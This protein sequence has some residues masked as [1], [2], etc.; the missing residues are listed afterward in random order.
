[1]SEYR[2]RALKT[3]AIEKPAVRR[4]PS[5]F[6]FFSV[7]QCLRGAKVLS[8]P[9]SLCFH[10]DRG[11]VVF[12]CDDQVGGIG[13]VALQMDGELLN[14]S[15]GPLAF[16]IAATEVLRLVVFGAPLSD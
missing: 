11:A 3:D 6:V 4:N 1:M 13:A 15:S 7:P 10:G 14:R 5:I 9:R 16:H 8:N 2:Y 12:P